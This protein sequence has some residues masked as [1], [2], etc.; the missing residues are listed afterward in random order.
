M[1]GF[2]WAAGAAGAIALAIGLPYVLTRENLTMNAD[3]RRHA[4][5][6]FADLAIGKTH[7]LAEG[8]DDGEVIV[9]VPG[10]TLP[11]WIWGELSRDLASAGYRVIRYDLL[12]RG[13]SDRPNVRYDN[14]LFDTQLVQL[15]A[16]LGINRKVH[17]IGLA[18]GCP[19]IAEFAIRHPDL[20]QSLCLIGPDGFGVSLNKSSR[21]LMTP[22]LGSYISSVLG[23]R[24]L[25]GRINE[26]SDDTK[27]KDW[28]TAR[29]APE[30]K[31][32]GFK[33]ALRSSVKNMPI[34]DARSRYVQADATVPIT[35]IWGS[36][37]HVTPL[38]GETDL[39]ATLKK[40][41]VH[42]LPGVGHLPHHE[43]PV[44]TRQLIVTHL[45]RAHTAAHARPQKFRKA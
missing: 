33:R 9:L 17:L 4:P 10:A 45:E 16:A 1:D 28:L 40:A 41:S 13:F 26:Y 24:V 19:I 34:H 29:Y 11:L 6:K 20:T 44:E 15:I 30:L 42:I 36:E 8:P 2:G 3:A 32:K 31:Y 35:V 38:P 5:G 25:L 18:F 43:R 14:D 27:L 7:W 12:G 39:K 23:N 21:L 37:D 22:V